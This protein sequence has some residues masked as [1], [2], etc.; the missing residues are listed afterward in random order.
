V[1][2]LLTLRGPCSHSPSCSLLC[3][4]GEPCVGLWEVVGCGGGW[5]GGLG[6][7]GISSHWDM[8]LRRRCFMHK[9]SR[10]Y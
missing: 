7:R 2:N 10:H 8:S 9:A 3:C 4:K 6:R 5:G 1:T